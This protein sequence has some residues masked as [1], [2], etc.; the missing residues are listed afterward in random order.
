MARH[1]RALGTNRVSSLRQPPPIWLVLRKPGYV[2]YQAAA[3]GA[4]GVMQVL[5][6]AGLRLNHAVQ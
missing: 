2:V 3:E 5:L 1:F 6:D 4:T